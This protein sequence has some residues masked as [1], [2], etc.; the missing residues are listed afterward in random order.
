[1]KKILSATALAIMI[2][3]SVYAGGYTAEPAQSTPD[4]TGFYVGVNAGYS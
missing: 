4:W 1:M 3:S 2:S